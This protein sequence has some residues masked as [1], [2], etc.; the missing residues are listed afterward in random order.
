M[1]KVESMTV[2]EVL[3]KDKKGDQEDPIEGLLAYEASLGGQELEAQITGR[4]TT[5]Y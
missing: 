4:R 5:P 1:K 2:G 3:R